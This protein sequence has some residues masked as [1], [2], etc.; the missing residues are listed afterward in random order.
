MRVNAKGVVT[1]PAKI[2]KKLGFT[3]GTEV[4][5]YSRGNT[6]YLSKAQKLVAEPGQTGKAANKGNFA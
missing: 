2:R 6:I 5:F 1:I 3:P 4:E